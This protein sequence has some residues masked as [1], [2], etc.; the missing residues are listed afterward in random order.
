MPGWRLGKEKRD[1]TWACIC[2]RR[3]WSSGKA[4]GLRRSK[5]RKLR[6]LPD[7]DGCGDGEPPA[8]LRAT[9][10]SAGKRTSA[11]KAPPMADYA[12]DR[13]PVQAMVSNLAGRNRRSHDI[14]K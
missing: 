3:A 1:S 6:S 11:R 13:E 9:P 4:G 7:L 5:R 12:P 10:L 2:R 8:A 14:V